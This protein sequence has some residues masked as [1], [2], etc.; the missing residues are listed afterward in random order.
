MGVFRIARAEFIKIFKKPSVYL[1]GVILAAVLVLSLL[2]FEPGNKQ[3]YNVNLDGVT[4]GQVYDKFTNDENVSSGDIK[5]SKYNQTIADNLTKINFYEVLNERN[6]SL[7]KVNDEFVVLYNDLAAKVATKND[8]EIE[9]VY[10]SVKNKI[11]EYNQVY[12][13]IQDLKS[14]CEFYNTFTNLSIYTKSKED[15]QNLIN[16]SKNDKA[17]VFVNLIKSSEYISKL[18][19]IY[20]TNED[21]VRSTLNYYADSISK[22]QNDYYNRV[23]NNPTP[24]QDSFLSL[25]QTLETEVANFLSN[26]K[27]LS[28][29][30]YPLVFINKE[31]YDKI[32]K[33]TA[34]AQ[35]VLES[36]TSE[37]N[38]TKPAYERHKIIVNK[39]LTLNLSD[40]IKKFKDTII[41][42]DVNS[43]TL[44][45]LR[46]VIT[47]RVEELKIGLTESIITANKNSQSKVQ[48]DIDELNEIITCYKVLT[49]NSTVLVDNTINLEAIKVL[50]SN[51]INKYIGFEKFNLYEKTEELA[52]TNYFIESGT[53]NQQYNDVFA[54]N[55]NSG[56]ETSAYD[57]MFY[58]ME[59][60]TLV[61]TIFAIFLAA[62]LMAS[63]YDSGTIKLLAMRPFK[64]WKIIT[65]K[66]LATMTFVFLFVLFSFGICTV[67]GICL[68]PIDNTLILT[69]FNSGIPFAIHPLALMGINLGCILL[70]IFFYT[71]IALSIS[72]IFRSYTAAIS[73]SCIMYILA[74]SFN[75][76]FGGA[77]WY[78]FIPFINADF[79]KFFGGSFLITQSSAF[80]TM[81]TP[82][83]LSNANFLLS[84]GIYGVT[85]FVF[86]VLTYIIFKVRDF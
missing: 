49:L 69:V 27:Q 23:I 60:A 41:D 59:I 4:V 71:I 62:S 68:Y 37:A 63:E 54:F 16:R 12:N 46:K 9:A 2:F 81:F 57:F 82:T 77:F 7:K 6:T 83:L 55:K 35:T 65:G 66:L 86:M 51:K 24:D 67:A 21:F 8:V 43:T 78:S 1:M 11:N 19:T 64:R 32:I 34:D 47:E 5:Q 15:L 42:F 80:N 3:S 61:I 10:T 50:D 14:N 44:S 70:E 72:T 76:L 52:R 20:S 22:K 18:N 39:L 29:S 85:V 38:A 73:I 17:S 28:E 53:Y 48:K 58:G 79:F 33:N 26:I 40:N 56:A 30:K 74:V 36:F 45:S 31:E 25:K 13:N 75:I 84:I